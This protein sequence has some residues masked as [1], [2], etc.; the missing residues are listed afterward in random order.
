MPGPQPKDPSQRRRRQKTSTHT[1]LVPLTGRVVV[2]KLPPCDIA[3]GWHP[4]VKQWWVEI[5][6]SP[7]AAVWQRTDYANILRVI[8]LENLFRYCDPTDT[9]GKAMLAAEIR[10]QMRELG[11]T[12]MS[13]RSLQWSIE[14]VDE[15]Q[16]AGRKRRAGRSSAVADP[17]LEYV[18]D[19]EVLE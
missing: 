2:P 12:P 15:V 6:S 16:D 3:A 14:K 9:R 5:W 11:L 4:V 17:R 8:E 1:S 10:L 7:M 19:A 18:I 13:L